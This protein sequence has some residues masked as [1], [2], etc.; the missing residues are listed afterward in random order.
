MGTTGTESQEAKKQDQTA[1]AVALRYPYLNAPKTV[2]LKYFCSVKLLS[3]IL[4]VFLTHIEP[5][6]FISSI[7]FGY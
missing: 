2:P 1:D 3:N 7:S 6:Q 4:K 5:M